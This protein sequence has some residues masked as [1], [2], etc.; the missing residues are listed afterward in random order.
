MQNWL[1]TQE[2]ANYLGHSRRSLEKWRLA[3]SGP[4]FSRAPG[5]RSVRYSRADL[6]DWMAQG[7]RLSTSDPG[8]E[9]NR[10]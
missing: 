3:G 6:D 8:L 4:R 10:S 5:H 1:T 2:A 7:L 9:A